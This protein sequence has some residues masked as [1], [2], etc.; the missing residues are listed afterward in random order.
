ML[1]NQLPAFIAEELKVRTIQSEA[2]IKLLDE[3]NTVPFIARYR[4][5]ATG[6]LDEEQLRLIEERLSYLRN[7]VKRQE[8]ILASIQAQEKLTPE[9]REAIEKTRKL[10]EVEDLYLP[11][12][13]K[14]RTRAMIAREKGLEPLADLIMEQPLTLDMDNVTALFIS[15]ENGVATAED[16]WNMA[17]DIVAENIAENA[18][19]KEL[20]RRELWRSAE[21]TCEMD[22]AH[23]DAEKFKNY[24]DYQE[25]VRSI[26]PH[27]ILAVNR[28]ETLEVLKVKLLAAHEN[29]IEK[30]LYNRLVKEA[31]P[32]AQ[33]LKN[34][35]TDSYKRLLFPAL[36]REIRSTLTERAE[37][38]AI[39]IFGRN[40]RQLLLQP[41]LGANVVMGLDPGYRTGCKLA[42]VDQQGTLLD[43]GTIY[44]VGSELQNQTAQK[45]VLDKIK[46]NAVTLISIGNGTASYETEQF[47]AQLINQYKLDVSYI[48]T[49]E[50]GASVYSASKL[51][52]EELPDLDVSI[53]GAVSIAR[54]IQDPLAELVKIEPK[55][56]GVGQYQHDV[57]QK[58]LAGTLTNTVESCVNHVGVDLNTASPALLSYV[59][60]IKSNVAKS[61]VAWRTENGQFKNR[62]QLLKVPKLGPAAF[63]QCAGFLRIYK[64]QHPLDYTSV[65]PESYPLAQSIIEE[66]GFKLTDALPSELQVK[67][68]GADAQKLANKLDSGLPT[69]KDI[70]DALAKPGRDPRE[71]M[72]LPLTRKN[73]TKLSELQTGSAVTGVVHN[74]TDFGV[75]VDIG[76]KTNGLIHRSELSYKPFKHP[77]DIVNVGDVIECLIIAIDEGRGR[78][79]LSLKQLTAKPCSTIS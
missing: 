29:I 59:A 69:V 30:L 1:L 27:R 68:A 56:I 18:Q 62:K 75:F 20:T 7:L 79:G 77:L 54:R 74:V 11:Y 46:K 3:G 37:K 67:A 36:E 12:K 19:L 2:A 35:I 15:E 4:K 73:I 51:A 50:A 60:G 8:E 10:Q 34:A 49:N 25:A 70:L 23:K 71:D 65:H 40:L 44:I 26:P 55:S 39:T 53:R 32:L 78:I 47:V 17:C 61:I 6:E 76:I 48:I 14:K 13:P 72:P 52:K 28:G 9:L 38:H 5:E 66:L 24:R 64:G 31:S 63:T 21:I 57:N 22:A 33:I 16:V 45:T 58:E 41:P 42:V 43:T